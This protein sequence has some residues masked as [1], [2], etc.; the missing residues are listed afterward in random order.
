MEDVCKLTRSMMW[1]GEDRDSSDEEWD[2]AYADL[3]PIA[4]LGWGH[5]QDNDR[6]VGGHLLRDV[7]VAAD[8]M[9]DNAMS[10]M[11]E[12]TLSDGGSQRDGGGAGD[13]EVLPSPVVV[14]C[15]TCLHS[16]DV[17]QEGES[18]I[19]RCI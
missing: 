5:P 4:Q 13:R 9:H 16:L 3:D 15:D 19:C 17:D 18:R 2:A 12:N 6:T 1:Q 11:E 7:F 10:E 8:A 14:E